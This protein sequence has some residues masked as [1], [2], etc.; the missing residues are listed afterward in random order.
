MSEQTEKVTNIVEMSDGTTVDFGKRGTLVTSIN[1]DSAT[2][3]FKMVTGAVINWQVEGVENLS[4]FQKKV[5]LYGL[6]SKI[7]SAM[8]PVAK[9]DLECF[10]NKQIETINSGTFLVRAFGDTVGE[11]KLTDIQKAYAIAKSKQN[12]DFIHWAN[13][14]DVNVI[15]EVSTDWKAKSTQEKNVVRRNP[16]VQLEL[17]ILGTASNPDAGT[18]L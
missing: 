10:I 6:L 8:A 4:D 18:E 11:V 17:S 12:P 13:V 2:I 1:L 7:K 3:V 16:Y 15:S 9:E 14:D 5:Y